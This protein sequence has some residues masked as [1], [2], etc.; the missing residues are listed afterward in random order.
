MFC[1]QVAVLYSVT[2]DGVPPPPGDRHGETQVRETV[3]AVAG[4]LDRTGYRVSLVRALPG[5]WE[6]LDR[7]R[8]DLVFNLATGVHSKK[9][10]AHVA[11]VLEMAGYPFTGSGLTAHVLGLEKVMAKQVFC[12]SGVPTPAFQVFREPGEPLNARLSFPLFVKPAREGSGLG[13]HGDAVVFDEAALFA[14]IGCRDFARLDIRLSEDG[15]PYVLEVNTLPGLQPGYSEYP[16]LAAA[17]GL[18]YDAL[19]TRLVEQVW[20]RQKP[21]VS[22]GASITREGDEFGSSSF[23]TTN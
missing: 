6:V 5:F 8:P 14:A 3:A 23:D 21:A 18:G 7:L 20:A 4:V 12:Q 13:I 10:Q 11:G 2:R 22:R 1:E 9:E 15:T 17:G 19:I 16:R